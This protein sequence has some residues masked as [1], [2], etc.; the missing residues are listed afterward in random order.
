MGMAPSDAEIDAAAAKYH[1]EREKKRIEQPA[2]ILL[3]ITSV[4][5]P[6]EPF[7]RSIGC[8][9]RQAGDGKKDEHPAHARSVKQ[10]AAKPDYGD[11]FG[12]CASDQFLHLVSV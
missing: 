4:A 5:L 7:E 6:G 11:S 3:A 2:I 1:A 10:V 8:S 9:R 12:R